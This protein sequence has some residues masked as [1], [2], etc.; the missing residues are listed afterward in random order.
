MLYAKALLEAI[1]ED[2]HNGEGGEGLRRKSID[3]AIC[4]KAQADDED[5][6]QNQVDDLGDEDGH[7]V[8]G[9]WG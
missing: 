9:R 8:G 7:E 5:E 2:Q 6:Q 1:H 3:F 4:G